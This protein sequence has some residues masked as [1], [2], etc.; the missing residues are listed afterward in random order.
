MSFAYQ[1]KC[2]KVERIQREV[3]GVQRRVLG[4]EHPD[5][6]LS[7]CNLALSLWGQW[8]HA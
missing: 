7:A 2:V 4:E 8:K 1:G 6:L 3:L 5:T